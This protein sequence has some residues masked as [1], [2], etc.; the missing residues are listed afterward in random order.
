[1]VVVGDLLHDA[2]GSGE[3]SSGVATRHEDDDDDRG[4]VVDR[5]R[6]WSGRRAVVAGW[7]GLLLVVPTIARRRPAAARHV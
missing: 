3:Q 7:T 2:Y 5:I 4:S 6:A 1:M